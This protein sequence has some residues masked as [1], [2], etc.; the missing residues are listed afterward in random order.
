[1]IPFYGSSSEAVC[2]W[3]FLVSVILQLIS[4]EICFDMLT[5]LSLLITAGKEHQEFVLPMKSQRDAE[6]NEFAR[7]SKQCFNHS[8]IFTERSSPLSSDGL[9]MSY[10]F[11]YKP[12]SHS[13]SPGD[14][15]FVQYI[16]H[17]DCY[18]LV[19]VE[20]HLIRY[21]THCFDWAQFLSLLFFFITFLVSLMFLRIAMLSPF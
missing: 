3:V 9:F 13:T 15:C 18:Q 6:F 11:E 5:V 7:V 14:S 19:A 10:S 12:T 1:M 4:D 17:A 2:S 16:R 21:Y 20:T 8:A